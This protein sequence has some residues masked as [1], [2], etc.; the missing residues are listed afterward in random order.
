VTHSHHKLPDG[1]VEKIA[2]DWDASHLEAGY[3]EHEWGAHSTPD[4]ELHGE[5]EWADSDGETRRCRVVHVEDSP[6]VGGPQF[7]IDQPDGSS[8]HV[9][10]DATVVAYLV[11]FGAITVE[12]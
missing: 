5:Y 11:R 1:K 7:R 3:H 9:L 6:V 4:H 10:D 12:P 2:R 8:V